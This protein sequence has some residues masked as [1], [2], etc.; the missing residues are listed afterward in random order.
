MFTQLKHNSPPPSSSSVVPSAAG[1]PSIMPPPPPIVPLSSCSHPPPDHLAIIWSFPLMSFAAHLPCVVLLVV[2]STSRHPPLIA[3]VMSPPSY[4]PHRVLS[5][6]ARSTRRRPLL[7]S[8]RE[9]H[10]PICLASSTTP[11]MFKGR[12]YPPSFDGRWRDNDVV[13]ST[14]WDRPLPHSKRRRAGDIIH[15]ENV[16]ITML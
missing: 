9:I 15:I 11:L 7:S 2:L 5:F 6:A 8:R 4:C 10:C 14:L 3:S 13:R 12:S 16:S 1:S